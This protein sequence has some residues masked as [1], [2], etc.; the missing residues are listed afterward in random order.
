MKKVNVLEI[1]KARL[2]SEQYDHFIY[3]KMINILAPY[4]GKRFT[5]RE[6]KKIEETM[7]THGLTDVRF[8]AKISWAEI[9]FNTTTRKF[10]FTLYYLNSPQASAFSIKEFERCNSWA[11]VGAPERI[12]KIEE[13][14]KDKRHERIQRAC[15]LLLEASEILD[16]DELS[17][18][19][20]P[21]LYDV[22][23]EK[24]GSA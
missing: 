10:N 8:F 9:E 21:Y 1:A 17:S 2:M 7:K 16:N 20:I 23:R 14:I 13:S 3:T 6:H 5:K 11:S 18:Y 15:D 22:E 12:I 4:E 19:H 24:Q